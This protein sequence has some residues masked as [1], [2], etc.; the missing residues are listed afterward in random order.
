MS[1]LSDSNNPKALEDESK[2]YSFSPALPL[3]AR[4]ALAKN[5]DNKSVIPQIDES[6][7]IQQPKLTK[8]IEVSP[9]FTTTLLNLDLDKPGGDP[10]KLKSQALTQNL[11]TITEATPSQEQVA[12]EVKSALQNES[13][14][15]SSPNSEQSGEFIMVSPK[16]EEKH[17]NPSL[18]Q[19][20]SQASVG[21]L[22]QPRRLNS[23]DGEPTSITTESPHLSEKQIKHGPKVEEPVKGVTKQLCKQ[24]PILPQ[25]FSGSPTLATIQNPSFE[26]NSNFADEHREEYKET[27]NEPFKI[28]EKL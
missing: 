20:A 16:Q 24:S 12:S 9:N 26:M 25:S 23:F 22:R 11:S 15:N 21:T 3:D 10:H 18:A 5:P 4:V 1:H 19:T 27:S 6:G 17:I 7:T 2:L 28:S 8:V 13:Q 14:E